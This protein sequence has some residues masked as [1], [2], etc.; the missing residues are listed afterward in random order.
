M[1]GRISSEDAAKEILSG[2]GLSINSFPF[3]ILDTLP[4]RLNLF[5][6]LSLVSSLIVLAIVSLLSSTSYAAAT[7]LTDE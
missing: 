6:S 5:I 7:N 1:M 3:P 2:V 4:K